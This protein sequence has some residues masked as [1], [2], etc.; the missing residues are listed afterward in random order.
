MPD[1]VDTLLFVSGVALIVATGQYPFEAAWITV[2][3]FLVLLYIGLGFVAFGAASDSRVR[4][5]A[6]LFALLLFGLIGWLGRTH[7]GGLI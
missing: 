4:K 3:L 7:G 1:S 6:W 2:K 5:S